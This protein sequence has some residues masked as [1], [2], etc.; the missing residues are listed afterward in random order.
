MKTTYLQ[1]YWR[2]AIIFVLSGV[3]GF[4]PPNP[5]LLKEG[6]WEP[7]NSY[8]FDRN[9]GYGYEPSVIHP[10][11]CRYANETLCK[12][13]DSSFKEHTERGRKLAQSGHLKVLVLLL[14]WEDHA[15]RELIDPSD[16]DLLWNSDMRSEV[17]PSG[18]IAGYMRINSYGNFLLDADIVPWQLA[19]NTEHF[20]ANGT[21][22]LPSSTDLRP[23]LAPLLEK[24]EEAGFDWTDY[25]QDSDGLIDS[26]VVLHSGYAAEVGGLECDTGPDAANRIWSH[27]QGPQSNSWKSSTHDVGLGGY[28]MTSAFRGTCGEGIARIGVIAHELLHSL[29][30]PYLYDLD[31]PMSPNGDGVGGVGSYDIMSNP[32]GQKGDAVFPG[33]LSPWSKMQLGWLVPSEVLYD[34]I[35]MA[36]ASEAVPQVYILSKGYAPGEYLLIEN[37][38]PIL[39]DVRKWAPGGILIWHIDDNVEMAFTGNRNRGFLGQEPSESTWPQNGRHY[40]VALLQADGRYELEKGINNGHIDDFWTQGKELLPGDNKTQV[41]PNSDG[42]AFEEIVR[43]GVS[44]KSLDR[45]GTMV[46]FE[47]T[48]LGSRPEPT[49]SS[50]LGDESSLPAGEVLDMNT[51]HT[52]KNITVLTPWGPMV[53]KKRTAPQSS[54]WR[55][56]EFSLLGSTLIATLLLWIDFSL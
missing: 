33:H 31:A 51:M 39:F 54:A 14:Q 50:S 55:V 26:V 56:R 8:R 52:S 16:I 34:G 37:R 24:M 42:Y 25:D 46:S 23:A 29:G 35:Y 5:K 15:F 21:S 17:A 32:Y 43:T 53:Y 38:V 2:C 18:S 41:F 13:M 22:G 47:V 44:I 3:L 30:L 11:I 7:V 4:V 27:S 49:H 28:L 6:S 20:Y 10:E 12:D 40:Q 48:G 9:I 1:L 36:G 19:D 45:S